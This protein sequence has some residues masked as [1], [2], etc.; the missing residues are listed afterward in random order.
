[1]GLE[2]GKSYEGE[3][4]TKGLRYGKIMI[5][6][7]QDADGSHIKGLIINMFR[8]FWPSLLTRPEFLTMFITPLL[9]AAPLAGNKSRPKEFFTL[10][11]YEVSERSE[12]TL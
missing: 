10:N 9:K 11:D 8:H 3:G 4:G 7:D 1:M 5:M 6:T 12:R 2:F